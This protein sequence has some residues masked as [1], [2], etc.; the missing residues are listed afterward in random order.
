MTSEIDITAGIRTDLF[1][2]IK[3]EIRSGKNGSVIGLELSAHFVFWWIFQ[4][5]WKHLSA[6][7]V[8][9]DKCKLYTA[10]SL[11]KDMEGW[12]RY[13]K[14]IHIA[15]DCC[16]KYFV[17]NNMLPLHCVNPTSCGTKSYEVNFQ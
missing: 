11:F 17:E 14:G 15:F 4:D 9:A 8:T 13:E 1:D 16:L 3:Y 5:A 12:N 10:K 6:S 2:A 7:V